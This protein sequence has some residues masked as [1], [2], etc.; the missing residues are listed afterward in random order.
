[1][2]SVQSMN[3]AQRRHGE[4]RYEGSNLETKQR[5]TLR[6]VSTL[7]VKLLRL[8]NLALALNPPMSQR[9]Q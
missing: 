7:R 3:G 5:E 2:K 4:S 1:M 6:V 9:G 8:R